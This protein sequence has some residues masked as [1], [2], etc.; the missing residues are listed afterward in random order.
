MRERFDSTDIRKFIGP[1][2]P[3]RHAVGLGSLAP[4]DDP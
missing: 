3:G 4:D 1:Q 2:V